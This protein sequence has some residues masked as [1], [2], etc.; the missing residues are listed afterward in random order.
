MIVL[1]G[2]SASSTFEELGTIALNAVGTSV[3]KLATGID[4]S[5]AAAHGVATFIRR[6]HRYKGTKL[7]VVDYGPYKESYAENTHI[8]LKNHHDEL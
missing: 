4:P 3:V 1:A 5:N 8:G 7:D 2:E 6:A